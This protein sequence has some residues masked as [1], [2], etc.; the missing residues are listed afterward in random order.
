[1]AGLFEDIIDESFALFGADRAGLWLFEPD[2]SPQLR[3]AA[4]RGLSSGITDAIADL[5][6]DSPTA[7]M[8]PCAAVKC[9]SSTRAPR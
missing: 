2:A 6:I 9:A 3:L 8:E 1:M 4:E 5:T 7:G